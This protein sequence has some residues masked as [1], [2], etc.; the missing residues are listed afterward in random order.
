MAGGADRVA[1]VVQAVEEADQVV[2]AGVAGGGGDLEPRLLV[3]ACFRGSLAG[4]RDG[5]LVVVESGEVR[6]GV[7]LGHGYD[8]GAVPAADI[9]HAGACGEFGLDSVECGNPD[10][11]QVGSVPGAEKPLGSLEQ[12]RVMIT[13]GERAVAEEG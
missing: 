11:R 8:G 2:A 3:N 9:G 5:R 7:G 4:G 12:A 6:A 10:A 13:P 1:H